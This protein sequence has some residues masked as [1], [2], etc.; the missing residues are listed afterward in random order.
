MRTITGSQRRWRPESS[1]EHMPTQP[2]SKPEGQAT[3]T[4]QEIE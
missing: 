4:V 1:D 3:A 2:P